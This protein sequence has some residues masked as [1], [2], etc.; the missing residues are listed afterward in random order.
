MAHEKEEQ[1]GAQVDG[2]MYKTTSTTL[3]AAPMAD[4]QGF[5]K[6]ANYMNVAE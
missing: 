2:P 1:Q 5:L 6:N 3:E 4:L